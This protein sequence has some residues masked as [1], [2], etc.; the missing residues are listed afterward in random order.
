MAVIDIS[1]ARTCVR[2][3]GTR[4]VV[5]ETIDWVEQCWGTI[6]IEWSEQPAERQWRRWH[7]TL[8]AARCWLTIGPFS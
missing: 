4:T 1:I 3:S 7:L 8:P 2:A 6:D 5:G